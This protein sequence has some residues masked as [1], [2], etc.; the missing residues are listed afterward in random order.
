V[1]D[2]V[3]HAVAAHSGA[4]RWNQVNSITVDASITGALWDVNGKPNALKDV[5]FEVDTKS[6]AFEFGRRRQPTLKSVQRKDFQNCW[7]A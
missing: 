1:N 7:G 3:K 4:D 5:R 2:L 6:V